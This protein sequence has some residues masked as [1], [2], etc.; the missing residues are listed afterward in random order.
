MQIEIL[1][2]PSIVEPKIL[3]VDKKI[4]KEKSLNMVL[5]IVQDDLKFVFKING[6]QK[7]FF[8]PYKF[9][10]DSASIPRG[11]S[12]FALTTE[13]A[14]IVSGLIHDYLYRNLLDTKD[15]SRKEADLIFKIVLKY[16]LQK[17]EYNKIYTFIVPQ[18]AYL[19]VKF[20]ASKYFKKI[21][22]LN[23]I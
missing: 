18:I 10:Y 22:T 16:L 4:L 1:Q 11:L 3:S 23:L 14:Y 17:E 20:L 12:I 2:L 7:T 15:V 21:N 9:Q 19:S 8:I 13:K 6:N 5:E